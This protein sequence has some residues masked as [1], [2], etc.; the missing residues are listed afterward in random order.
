MSEA[1]SHPSTP[2]HSRLRSRRKNYQYVSH[3]IRSKNV[4][5]GKRA[6]PMSPPGHVTSPSPGGSKPALKPKPGRVNNTVEGMEF[7]FDPVFIAKLNQAGLGNRGNKRNSRP[8]ISPKPRLLTDNKSNNAQADGE[9]RC[10]ITEIK[11]M[12]EGDSA[13]SSLERIKEQ[14]ESR[15]AVN[16]K[17]SAANQGISNGSSSGPKPSVRRGKVASRSSDPEKPRVTSPVTEFKNKFQLASVLNQAQQIVKPAGSGNQVGAVSNSTDFHTTHKEETHESFSGMKRVP[18]AKPR[19]SLHK[20]EPLTQAKLNI[21]LDPKLVEKFQSQENKSSAAAVR[22]K[23]VLRPKP[24]GNDIKARISDFSRKSS[25]SSGASNTQKNSLTDMGDCSRNPR[26]SQVSQLKEQFLQGAAQKPNIPTKTNDITSKSSGITTKNGD[27][28]TKSGDIT[29]KNNDITAPPS[30]QHSSH[31]KD[32][33]KTTTQPAKESQRDSDNKRESK[34][35]HVLPKPHQVNRSPR[36][37]SYA[38]DDVVLTFPTRSNPEEVQSRNG[39]LPLTMDRERADSWS[40]A[41]SDDG[42]PFTA[43]F[44]PGGK[45]SGSDNQSQEADEGWID[46]EVIEENTTM[47]IL[48][49][50]RKKKSTTLRRR[51]LKQLH[52]QFENINQ[53]KRASLN[54]QSTKTREC[55]RKSLPRQRYLSDPLKHAQ[56]ETVV[57]EDI[58]DDNEIIPQGEEE[59]ESA[60]DDGY[61]E[62]DEEDGPVELTGFKKLTSYDGRSET[63]E[64]RIS[65]EIVLLPTRKETAKVSPKLMSKFKSKI[66]KAA[67][68]FTIATKHLKKDLKISSDD[69]SI[70]MGKQNNKHLEHSHSVA[71]LDSW[72]ESHEVVPPEQNSPVIIVPHKG[73]IS[74]PIPRRVEKP[75]P[76]P[77][78]RGKPRSDSDTDQ[79]NTFQDFTA[80][81]ASSDISGNFDSKGI[82]DI[83]GS[84]PVPP[85]L[86]KPRGVTMATVHGHL[87]NQ[88]TRNSRAQ[89]FDIDSSHLKASHI[90]EQGK[91][92]SAEDIATQY[93]TR[94]PPPLPRS[95][96]QKPPR[97]DQNEEA[98]NFVAGGGDSSLAGVDRDGYELV[99]LPAPGAVRMRHKAALISKDEM[100]R[101][102]FPAARSSPLG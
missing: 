51:V 69:C 59:W 23:P 3:S 76:I 61:E 86:T 28:I 20:K 91:A 45:D 11:E 101:F 26:V 84:P 16:T 49:V 53:R 9:K 39:R 10:S 77:A 12:F 64:S 54:R 17:S 67:S 83:T 68:H 41:C 94:P 82:P 102:S 43:T 93:D 18:V 47:H 48:P 57:V 92:R 24:N 65:E 78:S 21:S 40:S 7:K 88:E 25:D 81:S 90:G 66:N 58:Y 8:P 36:D 14:F 35:F 29:T 74:P 34:T 52:L 38:Y 31:S 50:T 33:S 19:N 85:R 13:R 46:E 2:P 27:I 89:S 72:E 73:P 70:G 71:C 100:A 32:K 87:N 99:T 30:H 60:S 62:I 79:Y 75:K 96:P 80:G 15:T 6:S 4:Y 1:S 42:R 63:S 5:H 37:N 44:A 97:L 56:S 95:G 22:E 55:R 98:N